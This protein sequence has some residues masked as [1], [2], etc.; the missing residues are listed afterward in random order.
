MNNS[1]PPG[2]IDVDADRL[3][4]ETW[5]MTPELAGNAE[6]RI[7]ESG[8]RPTPSRIAVLVALA[9]APHALTHTEIMQRLNTEAAFDRVTLYRVLDWLLEH[10]LAHM[11]TGPDRARRYQ[12]SQHDTLHQHAHFKCTDCGKVYCL[13][14]IRAQLP[15][16]IPEHF[17]VE[18]IELNLQGCCAQCQ[19]G[20][21]KETTVHNPR[22][23]RRIVG[24]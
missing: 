9:D 12:L 7:V 24:R 20:E 23:R 21:P 22:H 18:S 11:I 17:T 19:A 14:G 8:Q 2:D 15:S 1:F 5:F 10:G 16:K 4:S 13:E 3:I 6:Q